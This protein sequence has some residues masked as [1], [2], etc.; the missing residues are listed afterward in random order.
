[1]IVVNPNST[2]SPLRE[3]DAPA[4]LSAAPAGPSAAPPAP[5]AFA[6]GSE[7]DDARRRAHAFRSGADRQFHGWAETYDRSLLN[8]FLFRPAYL[9]LLE[10]I[11]DWCGGEPKSFRLL[12]IGCGTG[13]FAALVASA[14]WPARITALDFVASM[15]RK[16]RDKAERVRPQRPA[17]VVNADSEHLPFADASFDVVTCS[18]SFHHYPHQDAVV[19]EMRRV[20]APG[21]RLVLIDGFRDNAV[22]W[23]VFDVIIQRIEKNVHHA[24]WSLVRR[25]F[26]QAGFVN[27]RQRKINLLMPLLVTVG[28][29]PTEAPHADRTP[30]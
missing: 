22:G 9:A 16:A 26:E 11:A 2:S 17:D 15:C 13:S 1:M 21:G 14:D 18:N 5:S 27:L 20:L 23:F 3:D 7:H 10:E 30:A 12:D 19:A 4:G 6:A 28:E 8:T 24:P 25:L 29:A